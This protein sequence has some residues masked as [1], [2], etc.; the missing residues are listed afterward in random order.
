M[1]YYTGC[2]RT[3]RNHLTKRL[4]KNK[5]KKE[6]STQKFG[7]GFGYVPV[8]LGVCFLSIAGLYLATVNA[9][10]V[11][12]AQVNEIEKEIAILKS[13][14]TE[15]QIIEAQLRHELQKTDVIAQHGMKAIE[16]AEYI[17]A[18]DDRTVATR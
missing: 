2:S 17:S 15:L 11:R 14:R 10:A 9:S 18:Y 12:G 8:M 16:V 4:Q 5:R 1:P 3:K 6:C 13:E 7:R